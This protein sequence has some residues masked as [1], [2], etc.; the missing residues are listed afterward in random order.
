MNSPPPVEKRRPTLKK[1]GQWV[2]DPSNQIT[3]KQVPITDQMIWMKREAKRKT[4]PPYDKTIGVFEENADGEIVIRIKMFQNPE[5][6]ELSMN[7]FLEGYLDKP[8]KMDI[9][10]QP[11]RRAVNLS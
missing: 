2:I 7:E 4:F 8:L 11:I 10:S 3:T 1:D 9:L 6:Y 5:P